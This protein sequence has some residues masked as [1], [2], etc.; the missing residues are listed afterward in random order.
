MRSTQDYEIPD[1]WMDEAEHH[2]AQ[3]CSRC[4]NV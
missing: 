1:N 3:T 4:L 2:T